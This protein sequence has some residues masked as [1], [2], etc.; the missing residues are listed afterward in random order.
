[1]SIDTLAASALFDGQEAEC[2]DAATTELRR[3]LIAL[4]VRAPDS[5]SFI[6]I[7]LPSH[8]HLIAISSPSHRHL[9]TNEWLLLPLITNEWLLLPLITNEWLLLPLITNEWLLLPN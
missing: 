1:V 3:L 9:I 8:R 6:T 5:I 4:Q 7:S 2:G